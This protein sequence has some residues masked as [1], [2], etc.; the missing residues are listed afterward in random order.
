MYVLTPQ[1]EVRIYTSSLKRT[2]CVTSFHSTTLRLTPEWIMGK[3]RRSTPR[4]CN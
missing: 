4:Q 3:R 1:K 2:S